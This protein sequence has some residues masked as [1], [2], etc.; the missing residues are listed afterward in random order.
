MTLTVNFYSYDD[1]PGVVKVGE[2]RWQ[3]GGKVEVVSGGRRLEWVIGE[4]IV[5]GVARCSAKG[6]CPQRS[7]G[8]HART[9]IR[10]PRP[11]LRFASARGIKRGRA[12]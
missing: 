1:S 5:I 12:A 6:D 10:L 9:G 8:V 7:R 11:F 4:P 2:L 3:S